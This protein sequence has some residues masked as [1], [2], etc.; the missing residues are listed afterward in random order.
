[1]TIH[2]NIQFRRDDFWQSREKQSMNISAMAIDEHQ[3]WTW[4]AR[5]WPTATF[6]TIKGCHTGTGKGFLKCVKSLDW[7]LIINKQYGN[8]LPSVNCMKTIDGVHWAILVLIAPQKLTNTHVK[9]CH[10]WLL[11][12]LGYW[13][14][15]VPV[16]TTDIWTSDVWNTYIRLFDW[17]LKYCL[18]NSTVTGLTALLLDYRTC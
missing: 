17:L 2:D 10:F 7:T 3:F 8:I 15:L 16:L 5:A 1:M 11:F 14:L 6:Q 4:L 9:L 18:G 13:V 12:Y